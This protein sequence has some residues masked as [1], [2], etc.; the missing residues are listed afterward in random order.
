MSERGH[1]PRVL[2]SRHRPGTRERF[3]ESVRR[4]IVTPARPLWLGS[5]RETGWALSPPW[6][7]EADL[8][9]DTTLIYTSQLSKIE[10]GVR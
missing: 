6:R 3:E 10:G 2:T 7:G 5:R 8:V 1:R 4:P 9:L